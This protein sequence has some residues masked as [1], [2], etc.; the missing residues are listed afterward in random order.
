MKQGYHCGYLEMR[1]G[2]AVAPQRLRGL[3]NGKVF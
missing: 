2:R 1:Y 3:T